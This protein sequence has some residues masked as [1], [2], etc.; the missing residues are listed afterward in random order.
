[1]QL[2]K[3]TKQREAAVCKL[4]M[5]SQS[6]DTARC[7]MKGDFV[8]DSPLVVSYLC[9]FVCPVHIS[10]YNC[11]L[12]KLQALANVCHYMAGGKCRVH[13]KKYKNRLCRGL[14]ASPATANFLLDFTVCY[15]SVRQGENISR[16]LPGHLSSFEFRH[17]MSTNA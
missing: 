10:V 7:D 4:R 6:A 8:L 3:I 5:R 13:L 9:R 1:M 15:K 11:R 16:A 17:Y 12:P 2:L 14:F